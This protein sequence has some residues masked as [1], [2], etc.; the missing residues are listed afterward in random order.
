MDPTMEIPVLVEIEYCGGWGYGPRYEELAALIKQK[1]PEALISGTVGRT[2]SF[3]VK[4]NDT[5]IHSKLST[6]AFPDF[7]EVVA[8]VQETITNGTE[9][10][11][12]TKTQSNFCKIL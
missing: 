12:V 7:D 8:I 10:S 6:M 9:P 1:V 2:T 5:V 11:K 3:E 4:V